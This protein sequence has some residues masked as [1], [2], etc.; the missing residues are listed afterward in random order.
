M[1]V[2]LTMLDDGRILVQARAEGVGGIVGDMEQTVREGGGFMGHDYAEL[3]RL[4]DGEHELA[5]LPFNGD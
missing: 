4:G 1:I 2:F 5:D 3:K